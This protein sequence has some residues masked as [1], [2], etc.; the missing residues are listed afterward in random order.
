MPKLRVLT[1]TEIIKVLEKNGFELQRTKG[2]HK[3]FYNP[4]TKKRVVVPFHKRDLP[5]GTIME[6]FKQA[7]IDRNK[8]K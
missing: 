2:S 1:P 8:I 4:E 3:I 6:I 5:K 7:G